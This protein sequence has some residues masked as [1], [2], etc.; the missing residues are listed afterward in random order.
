M[1]ILVELNYCQ[2]LEKQQIEV[3]YNENFSKPYMKIK[4]YN[5]ISN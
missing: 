3:K 5:N 1:Q 2:L 4:K